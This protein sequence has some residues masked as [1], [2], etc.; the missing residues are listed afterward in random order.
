MYS[1]AQHPP[2][3]Q[4]AGLKRGNNKPVFAIWVLNKGVEEKY[5]TVL[6]VIYGAFAPI[7]RG[8]NTDNGKDFTEE[9][10]WT[11][12]SIPDNAI[13]FLTRLLH[14]GDDRYTNGLQSARATSIEGVVGQ[15]SIA[16][17]HIG[18]ILAQGEDGTATP[19]KKKRKS[20]KG[21][22]NVED[23]EASRK[24]PENFTPFTFARLPLGQWHRRQAR[25]HHRRPAPQARDGRPPQLV[26][27]QKRAPARG[28]RT[29]QCTSSLSA[30]ISRYSGGHT[31]HG[32]TPY[33]P[34]LAFRWMT[35][36]RPPHGGP[37]LLLGSVLLPLL[38]IEDDHPGTYAQVLN[39][40]G[41]FL[42]HVYSF[43]W[44]HR[45]PASRG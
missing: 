23:K 4:R 34:P 18:L 6:C 31:S 39:E 3:L 27:H 26:C 9:D 20:T 36:I 33:W 37:A 16:L 42:R 45:H 41:A 13:H 17:N 1:R 32:S 19:K 11:R 43:R 22:G 38:L 21:K 15:D 14:M 40:T 30:P 7:S 44:V 2:A 35:S 24:C 5:N 10:L 25:T 28:L 8:K 29:M 12:M